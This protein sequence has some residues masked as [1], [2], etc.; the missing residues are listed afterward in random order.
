MFDFYLGWG[1]I[2]FVV[3]DG[4]GRN[5]GGAGNRACVVFCFF[6]FYI[7][8]SRYERE[9]GREREREND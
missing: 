1:I 4:K 8:C 2:F 7:E 6:K 5:R 3:V 9:G